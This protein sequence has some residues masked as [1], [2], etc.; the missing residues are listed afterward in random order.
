MSDAR[1]EMVLEH[2][3]P[4]PGR[5]L[6][7]GGASALGALRGVSPEEAVWVPAPGRHSIWA[8]TL[9]IA[10]WKYIVRRKIMAGPKGEFP[11]SP[12]N[13][14][15]VPEPASADSWKAD[16]ALLR[17]KHRE[18]VE[19]IGHLDPARLDEIPEGNGSYSYR[20][21]MLGILLHD[22]HHAGQIVMLKRLY[23]SGLGGGTPV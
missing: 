22:T 2:L 8:L 4:S 3:D 14:P 10:Y 17:E 15:R 19:S 21:L 12:S 1:I 16:R 6:W 20:D 7:H 18:L 11:R 13:F 23:A 5:K 9:H